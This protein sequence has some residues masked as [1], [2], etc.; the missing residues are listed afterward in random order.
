M[1]AMTRALAFV[2]LL[3]CVGSSDAPQP[4]MLGGPADGSRG[5]SV[6]GCAADMV[7][8]RD[9]A[10][11]APD[12]IRAVHITWTVSGAAA[13]ATSCAGATDLELSLQGH[14]VAGFSFAPVP[15]VEGAFTV[16]RLSK[17]YDR[18]ELGRNQ[19]RDAQAATIDA[20]G[21][22]MLDLPY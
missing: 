16:D 10:C 4:P 2:F 17:A 21:N 11:L 5:C 19:L 3:G 20:S 15:C 9:G 22:A 7:C 14:G 13:S 6:H 8:T 12:Q 18:V 1:P